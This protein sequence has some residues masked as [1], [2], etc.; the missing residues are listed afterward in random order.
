MTR[1]K[2]LI[3]VVAAVAALTVTASIPACSG[4]GSK[5]PLS[6]VPQ[7]AVFVA[8]IPS[9]HDAIKGIGS[10]TEKFKDEGPVRAAY[11][12]NKQEMV[13]E[14][15]FDPE[16]PATMKA[17]GLDPSRGLVVSVGVDGESAAIVIGALD[18]KALEKYL[19]E[20]A[21]KMTGGRATFQE[22]KVSGL[23]ATLL[24]LQGEQ[25]P[26]M[27][28]VYHKGH[29]IFCPRSKDGKVAEYAAKLA[30]QGSS[31]KDN[32]TFSRLQGKIGKH[33]AMFYVDG[34]SAKKMLAAKAEERL[35]TASQ[36]MKESIQK[37][38]ESMD[39][40]LAY[41]DGAAFG[42]ELSGKGAALRVY[43]A[44]PGGKAKVV[45]E[46]LSGQG[47]APEFGEFIG[48]DALAVAR[49]SLNPTKLMESVLELSPLMKNR[50]YADLDKLERHTRIDFKK[51]VLGLF[52]GRFAMALFG[53][54]STAL[55]QLSLHRPQAALAALSA[56]GM[57]QVT[58][59]KKATEMLG[60]LD[61]MLTGGGI[62]VRSK[63]EGNAR[64]YF[65]GSAAAPLVSWTVAKEVALVATG[66][67]MA[68]TL[69]LMT[70]GGD[71]VLGEIDNSRA[72]K[73]FKADDGDVFYYNLSKTADTI[74]GLSLPAEVKLMLSSVTATLSKFADVTWTLEPEDTG[75]LSEL[76]IRLK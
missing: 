51:D 68:K 74:R 61:R 29:V 55:K 76:A 5:A 62:D 70:K 57:A 75:V 3:G 48:P 22:K 14:L 71:N 36:W 18:Q 16:K 33:Q 46:I 24:V 7:D 60:K 10:L 59:G 35:K 50:L 53:P 37:D 44:M 72:K 17:K 56:V 25:E 64:I 52:S 26:K 12:K 6:Y 47:D 54:N 28:W 2:Q 73:L 34:P 43:T 65:I 27:A 20:T 15:G 19:R 21:N 67:R 39:A 41:L 58:D 23:S 32:K 4:C 13:K 69:S 45:R 49:F 66:D 38:R 8:L 31:I 30:S 42:V 1:L 9:V 11:E 40:A 63:T